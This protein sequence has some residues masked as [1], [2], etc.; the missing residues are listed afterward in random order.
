MKIGSK[1]VALEKVTVAGWWDISDS[2]NPETLCPIPDFA[3]QCQVS[4]IAPER[5]VLERVPEVSTFG[6][7][8]QEA[9]VFVGRIR[10][11]EADGSC[12]LSLDISTGTAKENSYRKQKAQ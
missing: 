9:P 5:N 10:A 8:P 11:V 3:T 6:G 12:L 1:E 4:I 2:P 7:L